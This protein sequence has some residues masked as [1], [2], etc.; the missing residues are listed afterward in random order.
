MCVKLSIDPIQVTDDLIVE[1]LP[2]EKIYLHD[3]HGIELV[4]D[5]GGGGDVYF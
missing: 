1:P 2:Y 4:F 5:D 3:S